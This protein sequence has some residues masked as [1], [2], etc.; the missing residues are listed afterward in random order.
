[1]E[2]VTATR[3]PRDVLRGGLP[4]R[5]RSPLATRR[6]PSVSCSRPRRR[7]AAPV[8]LWEYDRGPNFC[9][10]PTPRQ[11]RGGDVG[12]TTDSP[13]HSLISP[14]SAARGESVAVCSSRRPFSPLTPRRPQI[15]EVPPSSCS[16]SHLRASLP[17]PHIHRVGRKAPTSIP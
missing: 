6:S 1:M 7:G 12:Q 9:P 15:S 14:F 13:T 8:P 11:Q 4:C 17:P 3:W 16:E 10:P 2:L 5:G